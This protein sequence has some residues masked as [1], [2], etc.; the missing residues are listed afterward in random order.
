[1]GKHNFIKAAAII[2]AMMVTV[3]VGVN[4]ATGGEF[5]QRIWGNIGRE[6]V[7]Q[8]VEIEVEEAKGTSYEVTYPEI[9]YAPVDETK[10]L[11]LIGDQ[12]SFTPVEAK[13]GDTTI[14][15]L[16]V[17]YDG[18]GIVAEYT[19]QRDGGVNCFNYSKLTN[20]A[21]GAVL[22]ESVP[23][24]FCFVEGSGKIYVDIDKSTE[25]KLYCYEYMADEYSG[26]ESVA[27]ELGIE[28]IKDHITLWIQE[29]AG[30]L[31][32]R[33]DDSY[34][35][36][37]REIEIP[38]KD[39]I[40]K[41][42]FMNKT[43]EKVEVSPISMKL[44]AGGTTGYANTVEAGQEVVVDENEMLMNGTAIDED[45]MPEVE[46]C[47]DTTYFIGINYKDGS[48]YVVMETSIPSVYSCDIEKANYQYICGTI[49]NNMILL[50]NRLVDTDQIESIQVNEDIYTIK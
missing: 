15:V 18:N 10:A 45:V 13:M 49:D 4:A 20:E 27:A 17:V 23:F 37:T 11:E 12:I 46:S 28:P 6:N 50:F 9:E 43:G 29:Y 42:V 33:Q 21:K 39:R 30:P 47:A 41:K 26:F 40:A 34:I 44:F 14:T 1:M 25:D 16:S 22:N 48:N 2:S 5:F 31:I 36:S 7:S 38:V 3:P 24:N 35:T 8:H 19:L 32:N